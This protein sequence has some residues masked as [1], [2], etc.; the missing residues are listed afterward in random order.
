MFS[1][2]VEEGKPPLKLPYNLDEEPY[3]SA[4]RFIDTENLPQDYL[5]QITNFII[6]NSKDKRGP[7]PAQ[8][9][10]SCDDSSYRDPFTGESFDRK[11]CG[12]TLKRFL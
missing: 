7:A 1:V 9:S 2:D 3:E 8:E 12:D 5:E 4:Q 10:M 6:T 11:Q